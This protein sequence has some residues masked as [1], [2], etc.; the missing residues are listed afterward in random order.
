M[1]IKLKEGKQK[2]LILLAKSNLKWK[3]LSQKIN[4]PQNY[5]SNDIRREKIIIKE[6]IYY[7]LCKIANKNFDDYIIE[8][9]EDNWGQI[10]GGKNSPGSLIEIIKP[11]KDEKLAE[12]IGA[13]LGD[14]NI[15]YTKGKKIGVYQIKIAGD[16][17][18]DKDYHINYLKK[19]CEEIFKVKANE[20]LNLKNNERFLVLYSKRI[21]EFI[22]EMGINPG[23]K[24]NNQS[25]IPLWIWEDNNFLKSCIRGLIDTD[26]S[27]FRMSQKDPHLIRISFTNY[28][29]KLLED[30]RKA[31]ITLKFNPSKIINNKQFF[32]SRQSEI[33]KY[34]KDIGFSN[35][36]HIDRIKRFYSPVV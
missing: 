11:K 27:V 31:F 6:D 28:N 20:I 17:K 33:N 14:G 36:K 4:I 16:Y 32:I 25:T 21:V 15:N 29:K 2:E 12:F 26:G 7:K 5:L 34:L 35:N 22:K 30:T 3:E 10:K 24:M 8:K 13:V 18:Q 19:L 9:L 23:H 1:K